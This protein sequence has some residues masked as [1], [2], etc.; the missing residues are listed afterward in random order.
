[1][2]ALGFIGFIGSVFTPI[3]VAALPGHLS[4]RS[5]AVA[6]AV[7]IFVFAAS[8]TDFVFG[9]DTYIEDG[10]SRWSNRGFSQHLLYV[11]VAASAVAF[12]VLLVTLAA[13]RAN[14]ATVRALLV[15]T[16]GAA[17]VT[18]FVVLIAFGS[19]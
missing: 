16:G 18:G 19:N 4:G 13:R 12:A 8:I 15:F 1:V 6:G 2:G 5:R 17:F 3:V 14:V 7:A 10:S 9:E 11:I